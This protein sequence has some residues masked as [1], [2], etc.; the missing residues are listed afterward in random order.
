[1]QKNVNHPWSV[2]SEYKLTRS[3]QHGV[4]RSRLGTRCMSERL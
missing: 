1:M 4:C 3:L 2:N